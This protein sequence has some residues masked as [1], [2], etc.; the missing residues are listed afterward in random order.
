MAAADEEL[1]RA[2]ESVKQGEV[3]LWVW[4]KNLREAQLEVEAER[5]GSDATRVPSATEAQYRDR[6]DQQAEAS[7]KKG[8]GL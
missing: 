4:T 1:A 7:G 8:E 3:D 5:R 6:S 2:V